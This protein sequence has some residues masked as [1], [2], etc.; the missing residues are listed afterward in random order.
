[1]PCQ[2]KMDSNPATLKMSEKA[3]KYHFLPRKS[4][5]VLRNNSTASLLNTQCL[6]TLVAVENG[7]ENDPRHKDRREQVGRQ[8]KAEGHSEAAYRAGAEQEQNDGRNDRRHVSVNDRDPGVS[9]A[10]VHRRR[11]R[12]AVPQLLAYALEDQN[13]GVHAHADRQNHTRDPRQGERRP[14]EA[15]EA[16]QDD[17]V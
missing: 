14:G 13:V 4:I 10:L 7:L 8:T 6:A 9:K 17:Q 3:R 16:Q 2:K 1:M 5:L 15:E 11:R 12:L